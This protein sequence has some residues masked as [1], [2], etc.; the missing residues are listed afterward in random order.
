MIYIYQD[1]KHAGLMMEQN[2]TDQKV[3]YDNHTAHCQKKIIKFDSTSRPDLGSNLMS[4]TIKEYCQ[5]ET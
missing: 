4:S 5:T 1:Q 2:R 3:Y